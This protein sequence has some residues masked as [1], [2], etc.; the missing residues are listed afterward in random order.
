MCRQHG[1]TPSGVF[2]RP[3]LMEATTLQLLPKQPVSSMA[4]ATLMCCSSQPR[5]LKHS[6]DP[7]PQMPCPTLLGT[8]RSRRVILRMLASPS[9]VERDGQMWFLT[10][11]KL[12]SLAM[13]PLPWATTSSPALQ[14]EARP[15]LS[16]LS[17]TRRMRTARCA[18][19]STTPQCHTACLQPLHLERLLKRK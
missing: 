9:T 7:Q 16:T 12:M 4:M 13:L 8:R 15:K 14:M 19:S 2:P 6:F 3:I 18:S 10:T 17:A 1:P 11:T 5:Q